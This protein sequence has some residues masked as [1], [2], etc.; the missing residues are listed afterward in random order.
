MNER[1]WDPQVLKY[2]RKILNS[3]GLGLLWMMSVATA[4][5]YCGLAFFG[6]AP[7]YASVLFYLLSAVSLLILIR[8]L[9]RIWK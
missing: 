5:I 1:G 6:E 7:V 9:V 2:F 8:Y 3:F 4:G